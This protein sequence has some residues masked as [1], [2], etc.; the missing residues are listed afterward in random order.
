MGRDV[1]VGSG[2]RGT[3]LVCHLSSVL[4]KGVVRTCFLTF[5]KSTIR[6]CNTNTLYQLGTKRGQLGKDLKQFYGS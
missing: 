1:G 6:V 5:V 4:L 2:R 3:Y